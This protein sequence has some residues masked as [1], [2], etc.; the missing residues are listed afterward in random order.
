MLRLLQVLLLLGVAISRGLKMPTECL[1]SPKP[2]YIVPPWVNSGSNPIALVLFGSVGYTKHQARSMRGLPPQGLNAS[3]PIGP[4]SR[5]YDVNLLLP[6]RGAVDIFL[7]SWAPEEEQQN[8]LLQLCKSAA[9]QTHLS[10]HRLL[11]FFLL[12]LI[13]PLRSPVSV[14]HQQ[15]MTPWPTGSKTNPSG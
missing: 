6:S 5:S 8:E 1:E 4:V 14:A 12:R 10:S 15:T 3:L 7:F 2:S 9:V 13:L 11:L